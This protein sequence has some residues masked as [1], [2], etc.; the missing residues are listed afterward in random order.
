MYS[1]PFRTTA[2][3]IS[4]KTKKHTAA[5]YAKFFHPGTSVASKVLI[6]SPPIHACIPNHPQATSARKTAATFAPS[7]PNDA[8][9]RTGKGTPYFAP[10]CE[11]NSIGASTIVF[12]RKIVATACFQFMPP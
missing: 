11:F 2:R 4:Q 8:R 5:P 12:P 9:A 10:G 1:I 3:L 6:A 7:T